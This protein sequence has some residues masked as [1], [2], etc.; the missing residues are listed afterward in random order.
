MKYTIVRVAALICAVG[1]L[2]KFGQPA[3][4]RNAPVPGPTA[5]ATKA[6]VDYC[7]AR[8][9]KLDV[10]RV[11][12]AY[13]VLRMR[14]NISYLN[15]GSRPLIL[16]LQHNRTIYTSLQQGHMA[17]FKDGLGLF[18]PVVKLMVTLP[19]EVS[20][21]NPIEPKNNFF[22]VIPPGGELTPPIMEEVV[23]PVDRKGVFRNYPDLRGRRVYIKLRFTH[24]QL[25]AA[26]QADL[27][28]R[29]SRF[30]V[31]WTGTLT[32]NTIMVDVPAAPQAEPCKDLYTPAHPALDL[33][34][35]K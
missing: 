13:L 35:T 27:S 31:P 20:P 8:A 1:G 17:V 7:F 33:E 12:P 16:P 21:D 2:A 25:A 34:N 18:D 5:V 32:T 24:Q 6:E 22:A 23:M 3:T 11:P 26:L 9:R 4:V 15:E 10:E 19:P 29:W 28:D 14:V 30:G